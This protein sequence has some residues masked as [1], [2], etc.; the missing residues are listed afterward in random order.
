MG[1]KSFKCSACGGKRVRIGKGKTQLEA[2]RS[3]YSK[4]H[5]GMK[6]GKK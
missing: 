3:H 4:K 1:C 2:V 6:G 5:G